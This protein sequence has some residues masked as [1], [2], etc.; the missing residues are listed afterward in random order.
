MTLEADLEDA[1]LG[2]VLGR[3]TADGGGVTQGPAPADGGGVGPNSTI[4]YSRQDSTI[5]YS[6]IARDPPCGISE[7]TRSPSF[8]VGESSEDSGSRGAASA[9]GG[10]RP[11][12]ELPILRRE[13]E[14][15]DLATPPVPLPS[16]TEGGGYEEA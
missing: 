16:S 3:A 14:M 2:N 5:A 8:A 10:G 6:P 12:P 9:D 7:S 11:L 4:D 1:R 13:P 15:F